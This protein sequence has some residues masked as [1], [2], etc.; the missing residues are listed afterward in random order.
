MQIL[1]R[2]DYEPTVGDKE[3]VVLSFPGGLYCVPYAVNYRY[4]SRKTVTVVTPEG[5][6]NLYDHNPV[7]IEAF[8]NFRLVIGEDRPMTREQVEALPYGVTSPCDWFELRDGD[9]LHIITDRPFGHAEMHPLVDQM[10]TFVL[11]PLYRR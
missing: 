6:E 7:M 9:F 4:R 5:E 1:R 10:P 11:C 3:T 8:I 2:P